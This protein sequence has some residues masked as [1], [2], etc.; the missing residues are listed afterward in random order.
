MSDAVK[1]VVSGDIVSQGIFF[2][3]VPSIHVIAQLGGLIVE[4]HPEIPSNYK[5]YKDK[6]YTEECELTDSVTSLQK[7]NNIYVVYIRSA[8]IAG[9]YSH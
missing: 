3:N 4:R 6:Q 1:I 2:D 9:K 5:Y 8:P 7:L